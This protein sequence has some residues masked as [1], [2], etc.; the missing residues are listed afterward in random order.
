M[1]ADADEVDSSDGAVG[2]EADD[3]KVDAFNVDVKVDSV[4]GA[5]EEEAETDPTGAEVKLTASPSLLPRPPPVFF[6]ATA[7]TA[8]TA[9]IVADVA[10]CT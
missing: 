5:D 6:S 10:C 7:P 9:A 1:D 8:A 4:V 3:F 2:G